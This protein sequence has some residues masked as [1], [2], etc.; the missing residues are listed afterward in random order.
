M[1]WG[2]V[3]DKGDRRLLFKF[4]M[5]WLS[6][7][8]SPILGKKPVTFQVTTMISAWIVMFVDNFRS[9]E[10]HGQRCNN[11]GNRSNPQNFK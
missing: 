10:F 11:H 2:D 3:V 7:P 5:T 6:W 8:S 1:S 9:A 4:W